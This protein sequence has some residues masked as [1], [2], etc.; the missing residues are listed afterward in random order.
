MVDFTFSKDK[1]AMRRR[2]ERREGERCNR[3]FRVLKLKFDF[4]F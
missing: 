3:D 2:S 1:R 4:T